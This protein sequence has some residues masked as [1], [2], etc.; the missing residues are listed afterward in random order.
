MLKIVNNKIKLNRGDT[1]T[2]DIQFKGSDGK[3]Y[4]I[5]NDVSDLKLEFIVKDSSFRGSNKYFSFI[6]DQLLLKTFKDLEIEP[7]ESYIFDTTYATESDVTNAGLELDKLYSY[8][9][10][11]KYLSF[12]DTESY[13]EWVE[14]SFDILFEL[15]ANNTKDIESGRYVYEFLITGDA[16]DFKKTL[17]KNEF[18]IE[19]SLYE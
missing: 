18:I 6:F 7:L 5:P 10:E 12:N 11:Y 8:D 17:I 14:Y 1:G 13:Y 19:G 16:G 2:L 15:T 4:L 9:K 3:P